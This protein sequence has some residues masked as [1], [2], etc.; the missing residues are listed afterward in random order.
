MQLHITFQ[1]WN[2]IFSYKLHSDCL[3]QKISNT[4]QMR[5]TP[6][7]LLFSF[8]PIEINP[9]RKTPIALRFFFSKVKYVE[10]PNFQSI[11]DVK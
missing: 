11:T 4:H 8:I 2:P 3:Q 7:A 10:W 1:L 6:F 5:S 9:D